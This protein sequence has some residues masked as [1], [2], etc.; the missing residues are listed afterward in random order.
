M[1]GQQVTVADTYVASQVASITLGG[2]GQQT[3]L[4]MDDGTQIALT[5]VK[6]IL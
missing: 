6:T 1:N 3:Q 4:T 5:D 2:S